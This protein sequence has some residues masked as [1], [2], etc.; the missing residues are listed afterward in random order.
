[1]RKKR[2]NDSALPLDDTVK[3]K[4]FRSHKERACNVVVDK[5]LLE[6]LP[7]FFLLFPVWFCI[8]DSE[9]MPCLSSVQEVFLR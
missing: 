6:L 7:L 3:L 9:D 4:G 8:E 2:T 5:T 1:M